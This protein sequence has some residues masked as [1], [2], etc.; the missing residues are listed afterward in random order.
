MHHYLKH[1]P[2]EWNF[3]IP[4]KLHYYSDIYRDIKH[5]AR[6]PDP[7]LEAINSRIYWTVSFIY[8][9]IGIN[10]KIGNFLPLNNIKNTTQRT[11][12][13]I[14]RNTNINKYGTEK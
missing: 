7:V 3:P 13:Q 10:Q 11:K 6:T 9:L 12:N 8:M 5:I 1:K 14:N 4:N 2:F